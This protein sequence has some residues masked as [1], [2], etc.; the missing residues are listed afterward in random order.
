MGHKQ[1][2][3]PDPSSLVQLIPCPAFAVGQDDR[4]H[5]ANQWGHE[6]FGDDRD[7]LVGRRLG[8]WVVEDPA[9]AS[10]SEDTQP[11]SEPLRVIRRGDG[12]MRLAIES[13]SRRR[14]S[15]DRDSLWL[16]TFTD[17][18]ALKRS[19]EGWHEMYTHISRLS[20]TVIQEALRLRQQLQACR[21]PALCDTV[22]LR[23][24][25]FDTI[26]ML[27]MASEARDEQTGAHLRRIAA[28][29]RAVALELD[30]SESQADEISTAAILHDL[31]KLHV[32]D[33]VLRKN[34]KLSDEERRL[35][36]E[37]TLAGER[38]LPDKPAFVLPR[39][40]T[41]SHHENWDGTGYPDG[42][43]G[44]AIPHA[45]RIVHVV[46]VF[47]A[48]VSKRPYKAAWPTERTMAYLTD[49][50]GTFFEPDVVD[51]FMRCVDRDADDPIAYFCMLSSAPTRS[52]PV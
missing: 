25:Y 28:Y 9:R 32:P 5:A 6:L 2:D 14:F 17:V 7:Q 21:E 30:M 44:K 41:R 23:D 49:H 19:E 8:R 11:R 13:R 31:G 1:P 50:S 40:I 52:T 48:L 46:D 38:M 24:A 10:G 35:V 16:V 20:D 4:I 15:T 18:T 26:Y 12:S 33:A 29:T 37:H 42:L 39:Q 43:N 47:D 34:G 22:A 45:A 27:A 3:Q 51:A 36:Q